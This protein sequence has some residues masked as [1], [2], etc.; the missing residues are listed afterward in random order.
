[1][2]S[3]IDLSLASL[4]ALA[5]AT[6]IRNVSY[7][8]PLHVSFEFLTLKSKAILAVFWSL[9]FLFYSSHVTLAFP[10]ATS[11]SPTLSLS[12]FASLSGVAAATNFVSAV[13]LRPL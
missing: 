3:S 11:A 8:K 9:I 1:M 10:R 6:S 4:P 2:S 13:P 7:F 12:A 5:L